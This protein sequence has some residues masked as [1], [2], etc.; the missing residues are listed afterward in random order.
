MSFRDWQNEFDPDVP[1]FNLSNKRA[2]D[3]V[4]PPEIQ[5]LIAKAAFWSYWKN[6]SAAEGARV[7]AGYGGISNHEF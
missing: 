5:E 4:L 3:R 2:F 6:Q 1:E 7:R